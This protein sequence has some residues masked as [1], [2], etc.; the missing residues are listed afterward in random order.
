MDVQ[1]RTLGW[2]LSMRIRCLV[3]ATAALLILGL[4]GGAA[5]AGATAVPEKTDIMFIFDTSGS[6]SGVLEEAKEEIETLVSN[7]D[8]SLPNVEF[9]VANVEDIPDYNNGSFEAR[10][11]EREYEESTEKPWHLWQALTSEEPKVEKAINELSG[12]EV[13]HYGGDGPEA[14]G[15]ALYESATNADIGWRTGARHEIVL[16]ADNVPH[17]LNVNE[18]IPSE[19]QFTQ[20]FTDFDPTW[21]NT[22]EEPEGAFGIPGTQWKVGESEE[23]HKTL[24]KLDA[25]EKPLAMVDYFHTGQ[26]ESETF[27]HYW[28]YWAAD[29]G[30]QAI[31]A[32]E[33]TKSLDTK[34]AEIIK[35]SAEG[36]PPCPPG[37]ERTSTT[38]CVKKPTPAPPAVTPP[39]PP[40]PAPYVPPTSPPVKGK[41]VVL[42]SGEI[43]EE[44]EFPEDGEAEDSGLVDDGA[45]LAS[46]QG[47]PL[48]PVA[49][50]QLAFTSSDKC[51]KGFVRKA[52]KCVNNKPVPYGHVRVT[53]TKPG[54]YKF[55]IKPSGRILAALKSG[56]TLHVKVTLVFTPAGTTDHIRSVRYVTVHLPK[57][58]KK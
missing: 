48:G 54:H 43:E 32:D 2:K 20:E 58:H 8:S 31:S 6:M 29:T 22:G 9:G 57:K 45:S 34:L 24:Q 14:Y 18:G 17:E 28:E 26:P 55:R 47:D 30:G 5:T 49:G 1:A 56:K 50:Q 4:V 11:T 19:F 15:R 23:F 10:L 42:H 25:E 51:K 16:I 12:S 7:T 21:P 37:Y 41:L 27:I 53:V 40:P 36:I 52:G 39:S 33:G 35:E 46:F 44:D 38:P 3:A 13:A